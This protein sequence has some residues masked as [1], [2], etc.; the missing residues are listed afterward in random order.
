MSI[1]RD[2]T[3]PLWELFGG[4]ALFLIC[5]LFYLAWWTVS[6]RPN[7]PVGAGSGIYITITFVTGISAIVLMLLGIY[8][9]SQTSTGIPLLGIVLGGAAAFLVLIVI[10]SVF[11]SAKVNLG[12]VNYPYLGSIGD[13]YRC[14][15]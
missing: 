13:L 6:F 14:S 2:F 8:S 12:T 4:N 9:L 10:T 5:S 15:A 11:F 1:F 7:T 3:F